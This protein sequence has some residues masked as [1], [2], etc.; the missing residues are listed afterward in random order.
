M[1]LSEAIAMIEEWLSEH[2][3]GYEIYKIKITGKNRWKIRFYEYA[4]SGNIECDTYFYIPFNQRCILN[5]NG[6]D[7]LDLGRDAIGDDEKW[8]KWYDEFEKK[9]RYGDAE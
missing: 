5:F 3:Y 2:T 9:W 4:P 7:V 8:A 6:D 1:K